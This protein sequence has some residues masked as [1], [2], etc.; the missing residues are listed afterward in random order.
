MQFCR[1][2]RKCK[3]SENTPR[4]IVIISQ[5][6]DGAGTRERKGG[7]TVSCDRI[8]AHASD[9]PSALFGE[10]I[11]YI[12]TRANRTLFLGQFQE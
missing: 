6:P 10:I 9:A 3:A 7:Y 5:S 4:E 8:F 2:F 12:Q 1:R 11:F